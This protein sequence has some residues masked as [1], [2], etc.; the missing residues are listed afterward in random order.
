ML[1]LALALAGCAFSYRRCHESPLIS[2]YSSHEPREAV[3]ELG[4][5]AA[6]FEEAIIRMTD[7]FGVGLDA[8]IPVRV[9]HDG[10]GASSSSYYNSITGT[11]VLRGPLEPEA[12]AHELSHL[13]ARRISRSPAYWCDEALAQYME[14]RFARPRVKP[15][16]DSCQKA[17]ARLLAWRRA[18][19]DNDSSQ[20]LAHLTAKAVEEHRSWGPL[21]VRYLLEERWAAEPPPKRIRLLLT[22]KRE[23][24]AALAPEM[25]QYWSRPGLLDSGAP[26]AR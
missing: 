14:S 18:V 26:P 15:D 10:R 11:V 13:L 22:L 5:H 8:V 6:A 12:F 25:L 7:E 3:K 23:E 9:Y 19:E 24:V 16:P 1:A 4:R 21:V 20:V 2:I 17:E